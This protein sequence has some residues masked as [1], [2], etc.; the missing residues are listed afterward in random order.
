MAYSPATIEIRVE[1]NTDYQKYPKVNQPSPPQKLMST[2][3]QLKSAPFNVYIPTVFPHLATNPTYRAEDISTS[4]A[5]ERYLDLSYYANG[6]LIS[7]YSTQ[8]GKADDYCNVSTG[9]GCTLWATTSKGYKLYVNS[10]SA[11]K[12]NLKDVTGLHVDI[13]GTDMLISGL[14]TS[15]TKAQII[16]IVDSLKKLDK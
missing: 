13:D 10:Y 7:Y 16:Q 6:L 12:D 9:Q 1:S 8:I 14:D 15:I 11:D 5:S 4:P 2:A 3:E